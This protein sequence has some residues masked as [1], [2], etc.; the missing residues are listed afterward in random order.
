MVAP[1]PILLLG[2]PRLRRVC[3]QVVDFADP[4]LPAACNRLTATL[5]DFQRRHGFG[6]AIAAPQIGVGLRI[7]AMDP[8]HG[9][10]L[11]VNPEITWRSEKSM[12]LWDDCM[13]FPDL[14][15]RLRRWR[16]ISL[17]YQEVEGAAH[18]WDA[19]QPGAAE[20]LQHEIDH[21]DGVLAID[22][23]LDR[24]AIVLRSV[25]EAEPE[26]LRGQVDWPS[27]R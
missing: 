20:L 5:V 19:L 10:P 24:E 8:A 16:S 7:V 12:T 23:A 26:R 4:E 1:A 15:V 27:G 17:R 6:R 14:L 3:R 13:S 25:F 21:L 9:P 11:L 18:D 22:H 2:D